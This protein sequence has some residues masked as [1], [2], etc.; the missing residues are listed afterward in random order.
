MRRT[1]ARGALVTKRFAGVRAVDRATFDVVPRT[2]TALIGPNGAG[3][4][5]LFN[6]VTGFERGDGG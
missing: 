6:V 3:K 4:S 1:A 5:T 2:I